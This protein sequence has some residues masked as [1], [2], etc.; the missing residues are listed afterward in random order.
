MKASQTLGQQRTAFNNYLMFGDGT[1][2]PEEM[3]WLVDWR[4]HQLPY[5]SL[6]IVSPDNSW[7]C[8]VGISVAP[9]K[10][11][12]GLQVSVWRPLRVA[13]CFWC[14]SIKDAR[15]LEARLHETLTKDNKWLHGEWFD[16][17][18]E[19]AVDLV[20]FEAAMI[21]VECN[22]VIEEP[23]IIEEIDASLHS[24]TAQIKRAELRSKNNGL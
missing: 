12:M 17:R 11:V 7:P 1:A 9:R 5:C 18:P 16:M 24:M 13:H 21:G 3:V 20:Q 2:K 8:K 23:H 4:A 6:Y 15:S 10:R 22:S 14:P 19:D